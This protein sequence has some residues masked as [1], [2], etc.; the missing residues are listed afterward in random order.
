MILL[1]DIERHKH[2]WR[3]YI[4]HPFF[5]INR[6]ICT[7]FRFDF[8]FYETQ[9]LS[10]YSAPSG[11]RPGVQRQSTIRAIHVHMYICISS[12]MQRNSFYIALSE[13]TF[14][15]YSNC[16]SH[17]SGYLPTYI[18]IISQIKV[19][20][21]LFH[22]INW[23]WMHLSN[24]TNVCRMALTRLIICIYKSEFIFEVYQDSTLIPL[25][26]FYCINILKQIVISGITFLLAQICLK[27]KF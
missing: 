9:K 27:C 16:C 15:F 17:L 6:R 10:Y 21:I 24:W 4:M 23:T 1:R 3:I 22:A 8:F 18:C 12:Y 25:M 14:A 5:S 7:L 20:L 13:E 2:I 19:E 26:K 11:K